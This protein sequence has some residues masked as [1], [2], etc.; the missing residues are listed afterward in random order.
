MANI[1][2]QIYITPHLRSSFS[3]GLYKRNLKEYY[4]VNKPSFFYGL[5]QKKKILCKIIDDLNW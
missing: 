5:N 2:D 4:D 3:E 1:T